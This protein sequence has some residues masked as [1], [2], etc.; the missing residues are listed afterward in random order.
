MKTNYSI[1]LTD[2]QL[3]SLGERMT[4]K[5]QK[6]TRKQ[7]V[8]WLDKLAANDLEGRAA[9]KTEL[10]HMACPKCNRPISVPV[11][12][13]TPGPAAAMAQVPCDQAGELARRATVAADALDQAAAKLREL[14]K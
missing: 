13:P 3:M 1:E 11:P 6:A 2:A 12:V 4:G 7:I 10:R 8:A 5:R 14:A 9:A